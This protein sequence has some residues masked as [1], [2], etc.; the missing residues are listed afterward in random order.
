MKKYVEEFIFKSGRK[1]KVKL[2]NMPNGDKFDF[3]KGY[4]KIS[5]NDREFLSLVNLK[6]VEYIKITK[7]KGLFGGD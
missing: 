7:K 1:Y 5:T 3:N 4:C 2:N 6:E